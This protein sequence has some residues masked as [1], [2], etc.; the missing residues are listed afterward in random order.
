MDAVEIDRV[1]V[2][3]EP[4][5][6]V[7][8]MRVTAVELEH[9]RTLA[10]STGLALDLREALSHRSRGH[11]ARSPSRQGACGLGRAVFKIDNREAATMTPVPE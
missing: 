1:A 4:L 6:R 5:L 11:T 8:V 3:A 9:D 10:D 2:A 7:R